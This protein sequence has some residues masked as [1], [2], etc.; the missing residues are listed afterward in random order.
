MS[1]QPHYHPALNHLR[2]YVAA[3][4]IELGR[5]EDE[6][7]A[8]R[9]QLESARALRSELRREAGLPPTGLLEPE[10]RAAERLPRPIALLNQSIAGYEQA[11]SDLRRHIQDQH[12]R[13]ATAH[14]ALERYLDGQATAETRS[15]PRPNQPSVRAAGHG[16]R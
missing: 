10:E 7:R 15:V 11:L 13:L 14:Q 4:E 8:I 3:T 12:Y 16:L 5:L 1:P 9:Q 6:Q 2:D